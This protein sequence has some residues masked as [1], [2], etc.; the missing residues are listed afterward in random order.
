MLSLASRGTP[1][2]V[3]RTIV[4][5]VCWHTPGTLLALHDSREPLADVSRRPIAA[6]S[7][8][9]A[10]LPMQWT[11][12]PL[13]QI[14]V[15]EI[16]PLA[17]G[18]VIAIHPSGRVDT[19]FRTNSEH[20][21]LFVTEQ[22]NSYCLMCSQ[23][24]RR[25]DDLEYL[26]TLNVRAVRLMSSSMKVLGITG[27]EPTL[28]GLRLAELLRVCREALPETQLDV[29]S[30]GRRLSDLVLATRIAEAADERMLFTIPLYA[31][32][33]PRHDYIVQAQGAFAETVAGLYNLA[34]GG[35][36]SE[37]RVVLHRESVARLP[38]LA[39]FI[40]KNLPFVEQVAF[41]GMEMTGL[42]R[43][44]E[45]TL[46]IE[47]PEYMPY[48][49]EAVM[50]LADLGVASSLYNL[51][52]CLTPTT[53]WPYLRHSISDW[54]REYVRA[55]ETCSERAACGGVFGTSSR[56]SAFLRPL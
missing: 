12:E 56:L 55:C 9:A 19:L 18:D 15:S 13:P 31:D 16:Q 33:G 32:N 6:V 37:V 25:I 40:Q 35:V 54:K 1:T 34:R 5:V 30:N 2:S 4:G 14:C 51:P 20:N 48:L 47:P 28:L 52:R 38:Q 23:P 3:D 26:L 27:G 7:T 29:L 17:N 10:T 36:R 49:E 53:L 41:M 39:R 45:A 46:W 8:A 42:A 43:A 50:Y 22:C 11:N 21:A 24:P 44:H